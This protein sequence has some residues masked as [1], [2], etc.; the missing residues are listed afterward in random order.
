MQEEVALAFIGPLSGAVAA[1]GL[2]ARNSAL[3]AVREAN[4][5]PQARF[6]YRLETSDDRCDPKTGVEAAERLA[7]DSTII[8]AVA[9]YCSIVALETIHIYR[10]AGLPAV[11][12]GAHHRDITAAGYPEIFRVSGTFA[13][14]AEAMARF[15]R[16]LG[17]SR[18]LFL[19]EDTHYGA[20][21]GQLLATALAKLGGDVV[22]SE[23]FA[24]GATPRD[25]TLREGVAAGAQVVFLAAAPLAWWKANRNAGLSPPARSEALVASVLRLMR[26]HG[27]NAL[28][29]GTAAFL[30]D[31]DTIAALDGAT[32]IAALEGGVPIETFPG[33]ARFAQAY[34]RQGFAETYEAYGHYAYVA[35][36]LIID[37]IERAGPD[38]TAVRAALAATRDHPTMIGPVGF[39]ATGQNTNVP[40]TIHV[41][42]N[43]RW[44]PWQGSAHEAGRA[45]PGLA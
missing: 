9:H 35:A 3:L 28:L 14:E 7:A 20:D 39:D 12:W 10:R 33:G 34:A 19:V 8:A 25:Q 32:A 13:H 17:Y 43:R 4:A 5:Q 41:T 2:G 16:A 22:A 23:T 30:I 42:E 1:K 27:L 36:W 26:R 38:R 18:W 6:R 11:I 37:A 45:L 21:H 24:P 31:D 29:Q 15:M 40:L 44:T